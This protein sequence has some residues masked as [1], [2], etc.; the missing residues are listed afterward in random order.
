MNYVLIT[1]KFKKIENPNQNLPKIR[2]IKTDQKPKTSTNPTNPVK[3]S[4][5]FRTW[6][7]NSR[8]NRVFFR[9]SKTNQHVSFQPGAVCN[10]SCTKQKVNK[11]KQKLTI[12]I[13]LNPT[14]ETWF[15]RRRQSKFVCFLKKE[16]RMCFNHYKLISQWVGKH[17]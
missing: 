1:E 9:F 17:E 13:P 3:Y 15:I 16:M 10:S 14:S 7:Q 2:Q 12:S 8:K 4:K 5:D 11:C 6:F